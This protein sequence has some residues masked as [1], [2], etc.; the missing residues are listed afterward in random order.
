LIPS[1]AL[2]AQHGSG[3]PFAD[4]ALLKTFTL[5]ATMEN[6]GNFPVILYLKYC[7]FYY[8]IKRYSVLDRDAF[9]KVIINPKQKN[10]NGIIVHQLG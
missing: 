4:N 5:Y 3:T 6:S 1:S 7:D 10:T 8:G 2:L 9:G